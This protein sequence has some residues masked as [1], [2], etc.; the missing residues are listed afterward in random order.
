MVESYR[1]GGD[2][3]HLGTLQQGGVAGRTGAGDK[4]IRIADYICRS[5]FPRQIDHLCI[6]LQGPAEEW[7]L[8]ICNDLH[9]SLNLSG[10][11]QR[12]R[13]GLEI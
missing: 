5:F 10:C 3:A 11:A 4:G 6:G 12:P 2:D 1:G 9:Q 7:N 13:A 8:V